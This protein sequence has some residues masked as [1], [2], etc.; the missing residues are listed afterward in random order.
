MT[1]SSVTLVANPGSASRKYACFHNG[2]ER[3]ALHFEYDKGH[4]ICTVQEQ[5]KSHRFQTPIDDIK[6]SVSQLSEILS[7]FD[8]HVTHIGIRIVA[9]GGFFMQD[10][11]IDDVFID[12]LAAAEDHAP[13][14]ITATLHELRMLRK[15]FVDVP[16]V[17]VS[18]SSFHSA[19]PDYAWNYGLPLHDTDK[20]EIKRYG[21]HGLSAA[22]VVHQLKSMGKLP[23]KVI[24]CHLGSGASV[25]AIHNGKSMDTT[26]G[27]SPLDGLI[28]AT[29]SGAVDTT[30]ILALKKAL[31]LSDKQLDEYLNQHS[32][33]LGLSGSS[34]D[35]RELLQRVAD[36]DHHA[37]LALETY[38]YA[39]RKAIGQMTAVL[40]G[41]DL[42]VFT[43]T[44][45]ERS[46]PIRHEI[47]APFQYLDIKLD[48]ADN[49]RCCAPSQVTC[50]SH[51]A[52]SRPV[53]VVPV[54]EADQILR[55]MK[56]L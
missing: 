56:K 9:P 23:R 53:Y 38:V 29:R 35:I 40:G 37:R 32:G 12:K 54:D 48:A 7:Q 46:A 45:G 5:G 39:V 4:V 36:G 8:I 18:D 41:L 25:T 19:K 51:L 33:L 30:A 31:H 15:M 2:A 50:I 20:L 44:V 14:H 16:I 28:M 27:Y 10:H 55:Q 3:I 11:I 21:Y 42:L 1:Q 34:S 13:L 17:G 49:D 26:M 52:H 47:V 24:V 6:E 43:G 22:S